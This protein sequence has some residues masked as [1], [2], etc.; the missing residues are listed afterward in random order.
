MPSTP[1]FLYCPAII[2]GEYDSPIDALLGMHVAIDEAL[3]LVAA[4][5]HA[6]DAGSMLAL[7]DGGRS[8]AA[9]PL[10]SGRWA[11]CNT[12]PDLGC[13]SRQE[14]ERR[15]GKLVKRGRR[16]TVIEVSVP[17]LTR[18]ADH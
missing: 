7:V 18:I 9:A 3:N 4:A 5:W 11:G 14:A 2:C 13:A 15:L 10:A 12:F 1:L 16:G 6:G 8:V 17:Q